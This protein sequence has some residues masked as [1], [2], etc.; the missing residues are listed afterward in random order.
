MNPLRTILRELLGLFVDDGSFA[1]QIL[2]WLALIAFLLPHFNWNPAWLSNARGILLFLGLAAIL[3]TS[4]IR[5]A[6]R[7][8]N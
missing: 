3:M 5:Y 2:I 1:L 6:R 7:N 8:P 4:A